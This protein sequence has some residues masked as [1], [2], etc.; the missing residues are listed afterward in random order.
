MLTIFIVEE[1]SSI[2]SVGSRGNEMTLVVGR[3]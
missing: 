1:I 3:A 2:K